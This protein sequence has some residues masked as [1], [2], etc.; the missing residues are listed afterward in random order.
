MRSEHT[1]NEALFQA[2]LNKVCNKV[3]ARSDRENRAKANCGSVSYWRKQEQNQRT[4]TGSWNL[5]L[6]GIAKLS[7]FW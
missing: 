3:A 1:A 6:E 2:S 5:L 7:K 4:Q